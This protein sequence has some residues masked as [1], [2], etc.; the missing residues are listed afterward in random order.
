MNLHKAYGQASPPATRASS[1][2]STR[3]TNALRGQQQL[4][5]V[6]VPSVCKLHQEHELDQQEKEAAN[7]SDVAPH[8]AGEEQER[9]SFRDE[10]YLHQM[11][12][13]ALQDCIQTKAIFRFD[14]KRQD[15]SKLINY[16]AYSENKEAMLVISNLITFQCLQLFDMAEVD[17]YNKCFHHLYHNEYD[18]YYYSTVGLLFMEFSSPCRN[19]SS[20]G[21]KKPPAQ[22]ATSTINF[23]SQNLTFKPSM[24]ST[25]NLIEKEN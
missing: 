13:F 14:S 22:H 25:V 23:S 9:N 2:E 10:T 19:V 20:S 3:E 6:C 5:P 4:S 21:R 15:L 1:S 16:V 24:M 8:C 7:C 17:V 11:W 12:H 18:V